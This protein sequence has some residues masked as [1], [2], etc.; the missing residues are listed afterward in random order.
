MDRVTAHHI[1]L[2]RGW[3]SNQPGPFQAALLAQSRL[4]SFQA[5]EH[6]YRLGDEAGGVHGIVAGS[7]GVETASD[8]TE[9]RLAHVVRAPTWFGLSGMFRRPARTLGF[10]AL[11]PSATVYVPAAAL[12]ELARILPD[13]PRAIAAIADASLQIAVRALAELLIGDAGRRIAATLLRVTS[14]L[15]TWPR[16]DPAG[17]RLTQAELGEMAN[18]SRGLANRTLRRFEAKGWV[19]LGYNRIAVLDPRA[20]ARFVQA[21]QD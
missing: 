4:L 6:A 10:R 14:C 1:L 20:L 18:A 12:E 17:Y 2:D 21:A 7:F 19:R 13:A 9:P 8:L 11:E 3:L 5:G 15:E 16:V